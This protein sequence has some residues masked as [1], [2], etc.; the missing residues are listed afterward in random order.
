MKLPPAKID[1]YIKALDSNLVGALVYGPDSGLVSIRAE[2]IAKQIVKDVSDPFCS[3]EITAEKLKDTPSILKDEFFSISFGGGRRLLRIRDAGATMTQ[4]INGLM[5]EPDVEQSKIGSFLLV[6]AGELDS[7]SALRK[8]F[9]GAKN[10]I[11]VPCY[12]DDERSLEG[13][14]SE[15]LRKK[16]YNFTRDVALYMASHCQGDRMVVKQELEKLSLFLGDKKQVTLEDVE[17]SIGKTTETTLDDICNAMAE[18]NRGEVEKHYRKALQQGIAPVGILRSAQR[19]FLRLHETIGLI[20]D[21]VAAEQAVSFLRPPV[22]FKQ[23]PSFRRHLNLWSSTKRNKIEIA[24]E[25]LYQAEIS[26]KKTVNNPELICSRCIMK[27]ASL[28]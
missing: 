18:G 28:A 17:L 12:V 24:L 16:S 2:I 22:F 7:K 4:S 11:S 19:Y 1:S 21:G 10:A 23:V 20:S 8:E 25:S 15:A 9:E 6:T 5:K 13:I 26:C 14:I 27:V 3:V